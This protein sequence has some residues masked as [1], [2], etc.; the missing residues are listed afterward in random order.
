MVQT[1]QTV[2]PANRQLPMN[3]QKPP[4]QLNHYKFFNKVRP[5]EFDDYSMESDENNN[6]TAGPNNITTNGFWNRVG[7]AKARLPFLKVDECYIYNE[8]QTFAR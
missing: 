8:Q 1:G 5:P 6:D 7:I 2:Q 3:L 4:R